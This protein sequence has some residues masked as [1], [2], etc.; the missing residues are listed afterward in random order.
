MKSLSFYVTNYCTMQ[1]MLRYNLLVLVI[2]I[3]L[4]VMITLI[5][6]FSIHVT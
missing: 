3:M 1:S 5:I 6:I 4:Y 2:I